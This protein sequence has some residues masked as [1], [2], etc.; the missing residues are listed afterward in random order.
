MGPPRRR[1]EA[2]GGRLGGVI[3]MGTGAGGGGCRVRDG[4]RG[5]GGGGISVK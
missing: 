1:E 5:E 3:S 4:G 2:S